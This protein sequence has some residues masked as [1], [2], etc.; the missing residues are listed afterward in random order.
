M[1]IAFMISLIREIP[2]QDAAMRRGEWPVHLVGSIQGKTLGILGMGK[3]GT[4]VARAAQALE[5]RVV[6]WGP[7]L[8]DARAH[9]AG[10]RRVELDELFPISD[11][12]SIH[13]SLSDMSRG[14]V[15]RRRLAL[16][17]PTA[18]LINTARGAITDEA[19]LIEALREHRIAG[20]ALDVFVEEPLPV[21]SEFRTLDNVL[22][23]PH[24][25]WTTH[26]SLDPWIEMAV[27]NVLAYLQGDPIRVQN[28][29]A[30]ERARG[31]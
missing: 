26:E 4:R 6:A 11:F 3:I 13:L 16:L 15:D 2:Q 27:E 30:L 20:A 10:V 19:A 28:P 8:T 18:Y 31:R 7:T 21:D 12:V 29:E 1:T 17:K 24:A 9:A 25:G 22:L 23:S 14:L 5:M